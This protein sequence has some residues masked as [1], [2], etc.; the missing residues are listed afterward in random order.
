MLSVWTKYDYLCTDC[1]ALY[2]ITT[3]QT[4]PDCFEPQCACGSD[5]MVGLGVSDGNAPI[6]T[7][8][9]SITP[10]E[11]VKINSNPYN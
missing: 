10:T 5:K 1:D 2:E 4:I 7:D 6:I 11:L 9:T 3:L 8:V